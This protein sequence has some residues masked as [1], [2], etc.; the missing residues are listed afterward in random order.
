MRQSKRVTPLSGFQCGTP[1]PAVKQAPA[2]LRRPEWL[3]SATL[4]ADGIG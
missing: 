1:L 3:F 2:T 4:L